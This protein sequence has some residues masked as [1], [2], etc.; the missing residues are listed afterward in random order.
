MCDLVCW[1]RGGNTKSWNKLIVATQCNLI[2][3]WIVLLYLINNLV[4][5]FDHYVEPLEQRTRR[6]PPEVRAAAKAELERLGRGGMK[7]LLDALADE[8]DPAQRAVAVS[9]LGHLGNKA[10]AMPLV[11]GAREEPPPVDPAAPRSIGALTQSLDLESRV[12]ALVAAGRLGDP[13]VVSETL[14]MAKHTDISLR[15]AAV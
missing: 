1:C 12:A 5:L 13:R 14:P 10:A 9:V 3:V 4:E 7:A 15:E 11:R 8:S 6:G 2:F